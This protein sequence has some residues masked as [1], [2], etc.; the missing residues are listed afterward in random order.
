HLIFLDINMPVMNGFEFIENLHKMNID[1]DKIKIITI[2]NHMNES[3]K[4]QL[5]A[6]NFKH[7]LIKPLKAAEI[8]DILI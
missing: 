8:T 7:S 6:L 5:R 2:S 1:N 3:S 4:A